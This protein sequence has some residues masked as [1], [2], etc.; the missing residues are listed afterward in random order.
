MPEVVILFAIIFALNVIPAFAPPTWMA[1]SFIGFSDPTINV[2]LLALVGAL[3]ATVGRLTLAKL[4]R[5]IIRQRFLDEANRNNIDAIKQ[6]LEHRRVLTL[7]VFLFYAF[8]PF[9]SNYL[10]I[11][12]GLT[13]LKLR[14]IALPF[15]VGR[16]VSYNFWVF[17][18]STATQHIVLETSDTQSYLGIYF[19]VS[20]CLFLALVYG[21]A[22]I[23]W[24]ILLGQRKLR[25][26][27]S[28]KNTPGMAK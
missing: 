9:P 24:R 20:Q 26:L 7:S 6:V 13:S 17:G 11:A 15:F 28:T 19:V 22:K 5:I 18:V 27:T 21:F 10:F 2:T 23:D 1:L 25:W 14:S 16:F 4:A 3:A 12:Y 8:S